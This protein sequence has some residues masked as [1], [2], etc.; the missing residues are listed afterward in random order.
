MRYDAGAQTSKRMD[1]NHK[2]IYFKMKIAMK[3]KKIN[4]KKQSDSSVNSHESFAAVYGENASQTPLQPSLLEDWI[5]TFD[6][7]N[8]LHICRRTLYSL[9][10]E[11]IL[12]Y[13][14][15]RHKLYYKRS[16]IEHLLHDNYIMYKLRNGKN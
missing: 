16:D 1:I 4:E 3:N 7:M 12:P 11:G 8:L 10:T 5:D 6:V 15:I 2:I 13:S 14:R 9:R